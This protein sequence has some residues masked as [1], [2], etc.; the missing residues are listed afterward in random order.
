[1]KRAFSIVEVVIVVFLISIIAYVVFPLNITDKNQARRIAAWKSFYPQLEYSFDLM[2]TEDKN[3]I[4]AYGEDANLNGDVFFEEFLKYVSVKDALNRGIFFRYKHK[5]FNGKIIKKG[6]KYRADKFCE[7]KNGMVMAFSEL[8]RENDIGAPL[9]VILIDVDGK[10][11]KNII[12]RDVFAV[13]LYA[14][15][16]EPFGQGYTIQEMKEDCS[17][18]GS[19]LDCA[20]YYL[21]GGS[22]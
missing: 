2:K 21:Q 11:A 22:F 3:F 1:M 4:K 19:G 8:D 17:P 14:D 16:V 7:L 12:G 15:R 10:N 6:S 5:F 13:K 18:V 20:A 9:G